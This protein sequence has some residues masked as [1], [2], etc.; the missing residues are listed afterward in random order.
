[1]GVF[2]GPTKVTQVTLP[3]GDIVP[4][5]PAKFYKESEER[6]R[7]RESAARASANAIS[8]SLAQGI[9]VTIIQGKKLILINPDR[10]ETVIEVLQ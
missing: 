10:S 1:M 7:L 9:P 2:I 8:N 4:V 5:I 3:N 6:K